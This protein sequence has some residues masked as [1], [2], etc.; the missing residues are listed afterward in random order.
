MSFNHFLELGQIRFGSFNSWM[1]RSPENT[2]LEIGPHLISALLDLVGAPDDVS[3]TAD[4]GVSLP[5]GAYVFRRWRVHTTVGRTAVDVNIN[6]GPGFSQRTINARGLLGVVTA[7]L[8]ANTCAVD[9]STALGV[10]LDRYRR[11]LSLA[12]QINTQARNTLSDYVLSKLKLRRRGNPYQ[13]TFLDSVAAFY[14]GL[15]TD[16]AIDRSH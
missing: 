16:T 9:R 5:G 13:V 11:S 8:D 4:R 15:H 2:I 14:S 10:D 6:L 7:D 12:S 1:L 3:A